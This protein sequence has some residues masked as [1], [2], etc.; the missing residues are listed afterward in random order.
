MRKILHVCVF[1]HFTP[2]AT[3]QDNLLAEQNVI[4][5]FDVTVLSDDLFYKDGE[6]ALA[7]EKYEE[8]KGI[9]IYRLKPHL[10]WLGSICRKVGAF[11]GVWRNLK[12]TKPDLILHH[13]VNGFSLLIA[14][15]YTKQHNAVL[16]CDNHADFYNSGQTW[17][18]RTILWKG[19][20]RIIFKLAK[21]NIRA[22]LQI[23]P[24][25]QQ[26]FTRYIDR[27]FVNNFDFPLGGSVISLS[28]KEKFRR[29]IRRELKISETTTLL[30][31]SGKFNIQKKTLELLRFFDETSTNMH[32][33]IVGAP[34]ESIE[35]EFIT[36]VNKLKDTTVTYIPW[37]TGAKLKQ[38]MAASDL[39]LQPGSQSASLQTAI[40][41]R[42][43]VSCYPHENYT[44]LL[45]STMLP[46]Q[47]MSDLQII[48]DRIKKENEFLKLYQESQL[49]A[50]F[51]RISYSCISR[52]LYSFI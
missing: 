42:T 19:L 37:V 8:V 44:K 12:K 39:Y 20:Y 28:D 21:P 41:C 15:L 22:V 34:E 10:S 45:T 3:Y 2:D 31:H 40:C 46:L 7:N 50:C 33:L 23:S 29:E 32:L 52:I 51:D 35:S 11:G 25:T 24:E 14:A 38:M 26:F 36:L 16:V 43:A 30:M 27:E 9:K 1:S 47:T 13:G 49:R 18:S 48:I 5:G 6:L 4:D 17:V